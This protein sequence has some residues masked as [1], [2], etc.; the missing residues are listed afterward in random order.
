MIK[1]MLEDKRRRSI[2]KRVRE[3]LPDMV[4]IMYDPAFPPTPEKTVAWYQ[5]VFAVGPGEDEEIRSLTLSLIERLIE[6]LVDEKVYTFA[7][8]ISLRARRHVPE[9]RPEHPH[10]FIEVSW[11]D[12]D[13]KTMSPQSW[14][15]HAGSYVNR[16]D[17]S[18]PLN[19]QWVVP[20]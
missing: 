14:H 15:N 11:S 17:R 1:K 19:K 3:V 2:E 20:E 12:S 9:S 5:I 8:L 4:N 7:E 16:F 10:M 13:L 18:D 6:I